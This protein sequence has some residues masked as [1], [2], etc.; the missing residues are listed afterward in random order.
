[1]Y[2]CK[3]I[4]FFP[5]FLINTKLKIY[6]CN[7]IQVKTKIKDNLRGE[8][9]KHYTD[10]LSPELKELGIKFLMRN[11]N[12]PNFILYNTIHITLKFGDKL[13]N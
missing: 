12:T 5:E 2:A 10:K 7:M 3:D 8:I 4:I 6:L 9:T 13:N 11:V 1:V